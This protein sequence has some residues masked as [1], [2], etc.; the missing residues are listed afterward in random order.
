MNDILSQLVEI[1]ILCQEC[2]NHHLCK[3]ITYEE[4][5]SSWSITFYYEYCNAQYKNIVLIYIDPDE[6][7]KDDIIESINDIKNKAIQVLS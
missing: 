6:F 2:L 1:F 5:D 7:D 4:N 3:K